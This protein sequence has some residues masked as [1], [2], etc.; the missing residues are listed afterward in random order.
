LRII[1]GE[2]KGRRLVAPP[3][4]HTRPTADRV[5]EA[6]FSVLAGYMAGARVLDAFAGS[7]ALGL[8]AL[9]RGAASALFIERDTAAQKALRRNIENCRLPGAEILCGDAARL[10][11]ALPPRQF[12]MVFL[13][14]PYNQ[15]LMNTALSIIISADL[16]A[17]D[18]LVVAESAAKNSE[19]VL[20]P[21]LESF[22]YSVYGDTALYY[23][24]KSVINKERGE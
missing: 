5:R 23:C 6:M 3:G 21:Q 12:D 18:G 17:C 14:P 15:G 13:D 9:S 24:R 20:P 8:E 10:M 2:V 16:L 4:L 22:K 1:A 11:R 19:F 7:G